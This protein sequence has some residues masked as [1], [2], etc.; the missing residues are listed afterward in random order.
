M[1][2][3]TLTPQEARS[4]DWAWWLLLL[5]GM[6]SVAAG[7]LVLAKPGDSLRTIAVIVGIFLLIDGV[8]ELISAMVRRTANRGI[9]ALLGVLGVVIGLL[10]VRHPVQSVLAVALLVGIWLIA[11]GVIRFAVALD[12]PDRRVWH[13]IVAAIEVIAGIVIVVDP[14]IGFATLALLAGIAFIVNGFGMVAL[15]WSL[16]EIKREITMHPP[17]PTTPHIGAPV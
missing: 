12:E 1:S 15:G 10:L 9:A 3:S 4:L 8:A 7:V 14:N 2:T 6:L 11:A 17:P 13:A 5:V 16:H